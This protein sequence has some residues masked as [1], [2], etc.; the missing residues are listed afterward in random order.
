MKAKKNAPK[1]VSK[2]ERGPRLTTRAR[3]AVR[4]FQEMF[5]TLINK[6]CV[7]HKITEK[8]FAK[9]TKMEVEDLQD[10]LTFKR[11]IRMVEVVIISWTMNL[12][13]RDLMRASK[14]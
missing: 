10:L 12:K 14:L 5:V 13:P 8:R 11:D 4:R 7:D 3:E 1:K 9:M 2:V 6:Y